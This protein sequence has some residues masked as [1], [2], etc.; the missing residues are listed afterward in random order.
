MLKAIKTF[1]D[2]T[3]KEVIAGTVWIHPGPCDFIPR[4]EVIVL[5]TRRSFPLDK[6][7]GIYV[8]NKRSGEVALMKGSDQQGKKGKEQKSL[9]L[10]AHEELWEKTL[11]E[12]VER[13][14]SENV[15]SMEYDKLLKVAPKRRDKTRAVTFKATKGTAVQLFDF[16]SNET[17]IVF[18]PELIML[19]PYEEISVIPLSGG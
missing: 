17:R 6:N 16:K 9:M 3:D 11:S 18:G 19:G 8:R 4:L 12:V 13:L 2:D 7:E 5:E 14:I 15:D 1:T 10:A